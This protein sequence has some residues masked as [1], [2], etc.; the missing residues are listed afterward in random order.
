MG[1]KVV[2]MP[3]SYPWWLCSAGSALV[4]APVVLASHV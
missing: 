1:S 2:S 3:Q 4:E